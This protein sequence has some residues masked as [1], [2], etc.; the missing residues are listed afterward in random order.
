MLCP[1]ALIL[2]LTSSDVVFSQD[3]KL[4]LSVSF[5]IKADTSVVHHYNQVKTDTS[6]EL[7]TLVLK[8]KYAQSEILE[9]EGLQQLVSGCNIISVDLV[10]T[11]F[12]NRD[13]EMLLNRE[14]L[15][16]LYFLFPDIYKQPM[17][18]WKLIKQLGYSTEDEAKRMFHGFVIRYRKL[19]PMTTFTYGLAEKSE[20]TSLYRILSLNKISQSDLIA[21]D[22]TGSMSPYAKQVFN[23][24]ILRAGKDTLCYSFFNDGDRKA[25]NIKITGNTGGIYLQRTS[26]VDSVLYTANQ[27]ISGGGGGDAPENNIEAIIKGL[28]AFKKCKRVVMVADNWAP[29]RDYSWMSEVKK[30]VTVV[31][32]GTQWGETSYPPNP[33]YLD[34]AR[35]TG[36]TIHTIEEDLKELHKLREGDSITFGGYV[37]VIQAGKFVFRKSVDKVYKS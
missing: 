6:A 32:C 9:P 4:S 37:Y 28:Q 3:K 31:L 25:D 24:L 30:P 10:Y 18:Q 8:M 20:D 16:E 7:R 35:A 17:I 5:A 15:T 22:L 2:L 34:L 1:I 21:V 33:Q 36:G 11:D 19:P 13:S 29:M 12:Q 27:C 23:W 26:V 14:R